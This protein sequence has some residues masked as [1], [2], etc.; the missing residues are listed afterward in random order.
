MSLY[1]FWLASRRVDAVLRPGIQ[2]FVTT[3]LFLS[4]LFVIL[5]IAFIPTVLY[6]AA[7]PRDLIVRRFILLVCV[8]HVIGIAGW[9]TIVFYVS[10]NDDVGI[11]FLLGAFSNVSLL[12]LGSIL[13]YEPTRRPSIKFYQI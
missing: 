13:L 11:V 5:G 1:G 8:V 6:I 3:S 9:S 12:F 4:G 10:K 2:F 7:K